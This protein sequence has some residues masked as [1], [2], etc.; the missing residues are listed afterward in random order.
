MNCESFND[1]LADYLD[2]TIGPEEKAEAA[3]HLEECAACRR[4]L[5]R[6]E[7]LAKNLHFSLQQ[8]AGG[9]AMDQAL[10]GKIFRALETPKPTTTIRDVAR[11]LMER[12]Q[13]KRIFARVVV[14]CLLLLAFGAYWYLRQVKSQ[15]GVYV[16][17]IPA[18]TEMYDFESH[19]KNVVDAVVPGISVADA[20][21]TENVPPS[22]LDKS[23]TKQPDL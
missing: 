6:E 12:L 8:K 18:Q 16:V 15:P 20:S 21:F 5:A 11:A 23:R 4:A 13:Q 9:V 3:R 17:D 10:R 1:L 19:G 14:S 7:S 2:G 22:T